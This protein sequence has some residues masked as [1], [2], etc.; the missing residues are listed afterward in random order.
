MAHVSDSS[1]HLAEIANRL[2]GAMTRFEL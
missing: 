2:K 1:Q